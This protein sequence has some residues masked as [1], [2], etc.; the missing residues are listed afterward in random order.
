[1]S[2]SDLRR[3]YALA[4]LKESDLDSNPFRHRKNVLLP[5]PEGP[6]RDKTLQAEIF[7][8]IS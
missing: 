5:Q 8:L 1:M 6:I 7:K 2:L 4:G 3:E